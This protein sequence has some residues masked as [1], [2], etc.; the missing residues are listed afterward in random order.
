[1]RIDSPRG[2]SMKH[3]GGLQENVCNSRVSSTNPLLLARMSAIHGLAT[4]KRERR[5]HLQGCFTF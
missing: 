2:L 1:M 5:P 3:D 4:V